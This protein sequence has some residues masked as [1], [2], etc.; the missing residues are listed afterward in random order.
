MK[1]PSILVAAYNRPVHLKKCI[2]SLRF[3]REARNSDLFISSDGPSCDMDRGLV[4]DVREYVKCLDGFRRVYLFSCEENCKGAVIASALDAMREN[5]ST[6]IKTEDDNVFSPFALRYFKAALERYA[7]DSS[8]HA[9]C[10]YL[11]PIKHEK[12]CSHTLLPWFT[13]WGFGL[14]RDKD[15]LNEQN[16]KGFAD[17]VLRDRLLAGKLVRFYPHMIATSIE[18]AKGLSSAEDAH[19]IHYMLQNNLVCVFPELS[20]VR[21]V[22]NDASGINCTDKSGFENQEIADYEIN[23]LKD[24]LISA[25]LLAARRMRSYYSYLLCEISGKLMIR[26]Y[27]AKKRYVILSL[28]IALRVIQLSTKGFRVI[29]SKAGS[30]YHG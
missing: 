15:L 18:M 19:R 30:T 25:S 14:W 23:L 21:N 6:Y 28:R 16:I 9:V 8:V 29:M 27:M 12:E 7:E 17:S 4:Q 13:P 26:E 2:E 3:N 20:L 11:P 10:G 22:G 24:P 1:N 5:N